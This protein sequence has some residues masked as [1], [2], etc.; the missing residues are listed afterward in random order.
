MKTLC[1]AL[2]AALLAAGWPAAAAGESIGGP[3]QSLPE[4]YDVPPPGYRLKALAAV[5]IALR[6]PEAA[7][8]R[9]QAARIQI[10]PYRSLGG[11]TWHVVFVRLADDESVLEVTV[12]D[13]GG[14]V[15]SAWEGYQADWWLARG[16]PG[17]V[18]G[19]LN[20]P[21]A[22]LPLCAAFILPFFDRRR[23]LRLLH[24]DLLA[25]LAFGVS[26][27]FFN[28]G[29]LEWSAP[30][31][32]PVLLYLL[33]RMLVAVL[34]PRRRAG[35]LV[36]HLTVRMLA[37][38]IVLLM[39]AR[40]A[41]TFANDVV[42]DVGHASL[43]GADR[44][45]SGDDVYVDNDAHG[46]TYGPFAYLAYVPFESVWPRSGLVGDPPTAARIAA[47]SFDVLTMLGLFLLGRRL[48]AGPAGTLAGTA[49]AYAWAAYPYSAYNTVAGSNDGL[50]A[51]LLVWALLAAGRLPLRGA[52]VGLAAAAKFAPLAL[53]PLA[54]RGG[55]LDPRRA[56]VAAGVAAAVF[57]ALVLAY[58]PD[59]GLGEFWDTTIGFQLA[60]ESP[61]GVW[62]H[63]DGLEPLRIAVGAAAVGLAAGLAFVPRWLTAPGAAAAAAAVLIA[64]QLPARHWFY[65][66]VVWFAPLALVA[67]FAEHRGDRYFLHR[68]ARKTRSIGLVRAGKPAR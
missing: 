33:A 63:A 7:R 62:Y 12:D 22:W 64:V 29:E 61:F 41:L 57:A 2:A 46:D 14:R 30:L 6:T 68:P 49:L 32:Y 10:R 11:R 55:R 16:Q 60:R 47:L 17:V 50:I 56:A 19:P 31:V 36:P 27:V 20:A 43:I 9:P 8:L 34:A 65:F 53:V 67:L 1:A 40:V 48:R 23:P 38:G 5:D 66:Y 26:H 52:L 51:A 15:L 13:R 18:A 54:A 37:V 39:V 3:V 25:L 42:I 24:L 21:W 59:G 35:P 58:L 45:A 4:R 44:I 28:R